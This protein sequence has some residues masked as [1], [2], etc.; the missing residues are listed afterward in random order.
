MFL[1]LA[2]LANTTDSTCDDLKNND[3]KELPNGDDIYFYYKT[4]GY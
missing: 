4:T 1:F 3:N 2:S